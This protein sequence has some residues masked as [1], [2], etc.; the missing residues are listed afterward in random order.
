M[1]LLV[2]LGFISIDA[3]VQT[4]A[5][6]STATLSV[7]KDYLINKLQ[8]ESQQIEDD[9]RKISQYRVETAHLRSE[10]QDLK[11]RC[12]RKKMDISINRTELSFLSVFCHMT[13]LSSHLCDT[14]SPCFYQ[15]R[16][17]SRRPSVTCAT[18]PWSCRQFTSCAAIPS[19]STALKAT[20]KARR[21]ARRALRR[22]AKSWTCCVHRTRSATCMTISTDR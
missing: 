15:V 18:A 13:V 12:G 5:H 8:R 20:L 19:T 1:I 7:I 11:T 2:N 22:T 6:N 14:S 21:S 10:I 3:V 17:Y 16:R 9:E 4:L